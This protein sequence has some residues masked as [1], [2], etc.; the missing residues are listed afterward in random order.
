MTPTDAAS[1]GVE[2]ERKFLVTR[3]PARLEDY[4]SQR[5]EQGYL[6]VDPAGAVVRL[7]RAGSR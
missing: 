6:S 2:I 5:L 4:P 1:S 3:L 7:R